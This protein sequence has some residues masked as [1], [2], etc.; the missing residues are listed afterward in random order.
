ML[1]NNED[2]PPQE[3]FIDGRFELKNIL[4][5]EG[6]LLK[7]NGSQIFFIETHLDELRD[8]KNAKQACSVESAGLQ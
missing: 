5:D 8:V 1:N 6:K 7:S 2:I 4:S 3:I